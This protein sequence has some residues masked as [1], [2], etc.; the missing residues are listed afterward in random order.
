MIVTLPWPDKRLSPNARLHWRPKSEAVKQARWD[1]SYAVLEAAGGSLS[2]VRRSL[3]D[4]TRI[5]LTI[6]FYAPDRRH[7]DEDNVIASCKA[8]MDGLA[9]A[10]GVNDRRFRAFYEFAE[11]QAPGRVEVEIGG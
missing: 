1:A 2:E 8:S 4:Q 7:R 11:P 10:L 3:A 5:P 6:R 9:D